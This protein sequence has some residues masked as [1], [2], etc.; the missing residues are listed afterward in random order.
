MAIG[1]PESRK[2]IDQ[3]ISQGKSVAIRIQATA[4][5]RF[6]LEFFN[7]GELLR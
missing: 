5:F 6:R 2:T 1:G 7:A 3:L 4:A